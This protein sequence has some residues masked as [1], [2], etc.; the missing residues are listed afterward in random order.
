MWW[1]HGLGRVPGRLTLTLDRERLQARV[2]IATSGG[3][4]TATAT[5]EP[6]G[7]PWVAL[8]QRYYVLVTDP[9]LLWH[10]DEWGTRH[11]GSGSVEFRTPNGAETFEAYIGLDLD[12]GWDYVLGGP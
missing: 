3:T 11:D 1:R 7:E 9:P 6:A 12:V 2:R 5:F 10:G 8:P 4:M